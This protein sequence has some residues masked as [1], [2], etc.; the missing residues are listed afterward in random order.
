MARLATTPWRARWAET[1]LE[2]T[3]SN[4]ADDERQPNVGQT[5]YESVEIAIEVRSATEA[6]V[7]FEVP[8]PVQCSIAYGTGKEYGTL[9][10]DEM[11]TG[12]IERHRIPIKIDP[13]TVYSARLNLLDNAL[14]AIQTPEFTFTT[15]ETGTA[16]RS[17]S[18]TLAYVETDNADALFTSQPA[19]DIGEQQ[20]TVAYDTTVPTLAATQFRQ[21]DISTTRRDLESTPHTSHGVSIRGLQANTKTQWRIG[22]VTSDASISRTVVMSFD[23]G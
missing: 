7:N 15:P 20:A 6:I 18:Q 10:A 21:D 14:N 4:T 3:E 22:L 12:P 8:E 23:T 17:T 13:G 5:A 19:V 1:R 9:R 16:T 2:W 11:M